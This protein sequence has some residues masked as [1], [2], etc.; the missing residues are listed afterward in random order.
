VLSVLLPELDHR[1]QRP[2]VF[3]GTSAGAINAV[4]FARLAHLSAREAT[5]EALKLWRSM[6]KSMVFNSIVG[7]APAAGLRYLAGL[8]NLPTSL[9]GGLLDTSPLRNTLESGLDWEKLHDNVHSGRVQVALATTAMR[10]GRTEIFI[11]RAGA[12]KL[13]ADVERAVD[14]V[15]AIL[16]PEHVMA[17]AALPMLFPPVRLGTQNDGGWYMDGGVRLSA[18]LKPAIALGVSR[19]VVVATDPVKHVERPLA[20]K[21]GPPPVIQDGFTQLL[22]GV[23]VDNM[24]EDLRALKR[25]NR[26]VDFAAA[27]AKSPTGREYRVIEHLFAGPDPGQ[28][29]ELGLLANSVLTTRFAGVRALQRLDLGLLSFLLGPSTSRGEL[30]SYLLFEPEFIDEAI[31]QGQRDGQRILD[32]VGGGSI[33]QTIE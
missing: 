22:N 25:I 5:E 8:F 15:D 33:W 2:T 13:D 1:G 6:D 18:P 19:L 28:V 20:S 26:L 24:I 23:L 10:T 4:L 29:D 3:I 30:L 17:S 31:R 14:Y 16:T 11:E 27:G 32:R 7:T 9:T 21:P 12:D